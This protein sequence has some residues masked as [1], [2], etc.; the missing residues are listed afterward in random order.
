MTKRSQEH[1]RQR[2]SF[3]EQLKSKGWLDG[4]AFESELKRLMEAWENSRPYAVTAPRQ[5]AEHVEREYNAVHWGMFSQN[6]NVVSVIDGVDFATELRDT[7]T[8]ECL[9]SFKPD[10][11]NEGTFTFSG[12]SP[13]GKMLVTITLFGIQA[14]VWHAAS[15]TLKQTIQCDER[16]ADGTLGSFAAACMSRNN[17]LILTA[18]GHKTAELWCVDSGRSVLAFGDVGKDVWSAMFSADEMLVL[19]AARTSSTLWCATTGSRKQI[20]HH[21]AVV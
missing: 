3:R 12:F 13:D 20:L 21:G 1:G 10:A 15:G 6:G 18:G 11:T 9:Q 2:S 4:A 8:G 14:K 19:T 5:G 17:K 16:L 7:S